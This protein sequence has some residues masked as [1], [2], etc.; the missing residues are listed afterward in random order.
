MRGRIDTH[1]HFY[2]PKYLTAAAEHLRQVTHVHFPRIQ[3]WTASQAIEAMDRDGIDAAVLSIAG[4]GIWFGNLTATRRLAREC[5][6]Y[7][8]ELARD[9]KGRFGI[10]A[11]LPLPDVKGSL[12]EIEYAFDVLKADGIGLVTNYESKWPGDSAFAPVFDE[13]NRRNAVVYFH[14]TAA[15]AFEGIL[16]HVPSPM[17]EFP[18][19]TTRAIT[20][21]LFGGTLS[22]CP[23]I[24]FI[25]SHGGGV[26]P[27]LAGRIE[28]ITR[29]RPD[30]AERVPNGVMHEI[31]RLYY[32]I[33]SVNH[34]IAFNAVRQL[35]GTS[36]LLFGTDFP[37]WSPQVAISG[38][39]AFGLPASERRAI[40][41]ENALAMMPQLI[42]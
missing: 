31:K 10:F 19:D 11:A 35:V 16:P 18:V 40:E 6:D 37:F 25:F 24:R 4:P 21:L 12:E 26:L 36:Q 30:L 22:R 28:A 39:E 41:R 2:P 14:P 7:A 1:H 3:Q 33:A 23:D 17:I 13:L 34:V 20:S 32:D 15:A 9:H 42:R 27:M 8:A 5:N 38:L 29:N